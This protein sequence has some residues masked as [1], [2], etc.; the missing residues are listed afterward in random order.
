MLTDEALEN[1]PWLMPCAEWFVVF[2]ASPKKILASRKWQKE[3]NPDV[4]FMRPWEWGEVYAGY[5]YESFI[6]PLG[7]ATSLTVSSVQGIQET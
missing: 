1:Y 3:R 6:Y 4:Y 7:K 2:A 5:W